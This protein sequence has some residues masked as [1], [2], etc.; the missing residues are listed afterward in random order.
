VEEAGFNEQT[1]KQNKRPDAKTITNVQTLY[2]RPFAYGSGP[3]GA[4][5]GS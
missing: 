3:V 4:S 2:H 5:V 1:T